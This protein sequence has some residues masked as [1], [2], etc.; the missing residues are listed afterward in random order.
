MAQ[1]GIVLGAGIAGLCAARVLADHCGSVTLLERDRLQDAAAPRDGVPQGSQNHGLLMRG[2]EVLEALFPG[3]TDELLA[4]GASSGDLC[5]IRRWMFGHRYRRFDSELK[6][7]TMT[8]PFLE[9]AIVRRLRAD[10][11]IRLMDG[12]EVT[13]PVIAGAAVTGVRAHAGGSDTEFAGSLVIDARGRAAPHAEWRQMLGCATPPV[14]ATPTGTNYATEILRLPDPSRVGS[15]LI[16]ADQNVKGGLIVLNVE[17]GLTLL[18]VGRAVEMDV[19]TDHDGIVAF[20]QSLAVPDAAEL[21][22]GA[23]AVSPVKRFRFV[24]STRRDFDTADRHPA[25]LIAL[26][27]A[28]AS[29]NPIYGQGM[30]VAAIEAELLGGLL[31]RGLDPADP[32]L[33]GQF[34]AAIRGLIDQAWGPVQAEF[35]RFRMEREPD[36]KPAWGERFV[37]WYANKLHAACAKSQTVTRTFMRVQNLL[38]T[39]RALFRPDVFLRVVTA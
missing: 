4:S 29:F 17:G 1:H 38:E 18:T 10:P 36:F 39:P 25:G 35:G 37:Y 30:S 9:A 26:G 13:G 31:A 12:V 21:I 23:E 22:R 5:Q 8:R 19:P 15:G 11:R 16:V 32:A 20:A 3:L 6:G 2:R 14:V 34:Y 7:I 24:A 27:D 33:P 28:I